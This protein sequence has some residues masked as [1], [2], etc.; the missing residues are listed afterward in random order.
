MYKY[1]YTQ[2][3][4]NQL[5]FATSLFHDLYVQYFVATSFFLANWPKINKAVKD[6]IEAKNDR[7]EQ[8][9][10]QASYEVFFSRTKNLFY[11]G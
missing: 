9:I 5:Q 1:L 8:V 10:P 11:N 3:P 7:D 4:V 6:W 2:N